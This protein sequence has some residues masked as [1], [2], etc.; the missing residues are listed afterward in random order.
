MLILLLRHAGPKFCATAILVVALASAVYAGGWAVVTV[1]DL[2]ECVVSGQRVSLTFTVRQHGVHLLGGLSP[3][4]RATA[5]SGGEVTASAWATPVTGEYTA[6]LTFPQKGTW[7]I[8][9][10]SGFLTNSVT[11]PP[12]AVIAPDEPSPQPLPEALRGERLFIAK[13]CAS[14]HLHEAI[15]S[16]R[17]FGVG[18]DLSRKHSPADRLERF[19][20]DPGPG[21]EY[22]QMPNLGLAPRE[23]AELIAFINQQ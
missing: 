21:S 1:K 10:E 8:A 7:T 11:L 5:A 23:I 19:L 18:P 22:G 3:K 2:P 6:A 20:A 17:S 14:C 13:G 12:L 15:R 9:I 4:V 16:V